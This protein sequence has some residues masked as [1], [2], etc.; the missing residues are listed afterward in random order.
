LSK[1]LSIKVIHSQGGGIFFQWGYFADT[2]SSDTNGRTFWCKT[3]RIFRIYGASARTRRVEPVRTFCG[4]GGR[5]IKLSWF[6]AD[7]FYG[8]P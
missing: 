4:Q 8:R 6:C 7:I 3:L 2:G 5:G 1:E